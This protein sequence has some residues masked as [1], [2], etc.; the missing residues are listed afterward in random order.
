MAAERQAADGEEEFTVSVSLPTMQGLKE[1]ISY[2]S[3]FAGQAGTESLSERSPSSS[4]AASPA[5]AARA[6][7]GQSLSAEA[8]ATAEAPTAPASAMVAHSQLVQLSLPK[9][10]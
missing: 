1:L 8:R 10:L 2:Y 9:A 4:S 3:P 7:K 5:S 6:S